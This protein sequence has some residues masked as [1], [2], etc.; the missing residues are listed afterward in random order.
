MIGLF[1]SESVVAEVCRNCPAVVW[2]PDGPGCGL[3]VMSWYVVNI[4]AVRCVLE[5]DDFSANRPSYHWCSDAV[6]STMLSTLD[7]GLFSGWTA[8][9][10]R[11]P[12]TAVS[13]DSN[14]RYPPCPAGVSSVD[15]CWSTKSWALKM[16]DS[17]LKNSSRVGHGGTHHMQ[18]MGRLGFLHNKMC[19]F[20]RSSPRR[21]MSSREI[22]V[23]PDSK[24]R[25]QGVQ[26][27]K[28]CRLMT[29]KKRSCEGRQCQRSSVETVNQSCLFCLSFSSF[30]SFSFSWEENPKLS[31]DKPSCTNC[32]RLKRVAPCPTVVVG[33]SDIMVRYSNRGMMAMCGYRGYH[34][35]TE[36]QL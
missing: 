18:F 23:S 28:P 35:K 33:S 9:E 11:G 2:N 22:S 8:G 26:R 21:T 7:H 3:K 31:Q 27:S 20:R 1:Y 32:G 14:C 4:F 6:Y 19:F 29:R 15:Q 16:A 17:R 24:A 34:D 36:L 13:A 30:S 25:V 5:K 10:I 12:V